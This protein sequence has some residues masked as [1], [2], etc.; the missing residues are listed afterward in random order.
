MTGAH[1]CTDVTGFGLLGHLLGMMRAS[2][3]SALITAQQVPLMAK[4]YDLAAAGIVPGGSKNNLDYTA[5]H[6]E[7]AGGISKVMQS[8]LNDA[9]TSGGLLV[10]LPREAAEHF[11]NEM[12]SRNE[13]AVIVGEVVAARTKSIAVR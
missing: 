10:S 13:L 6:V 4:A 5:P 11:I 7:Y 9:Q 1:A 12:K 2:H 3:T 8:L